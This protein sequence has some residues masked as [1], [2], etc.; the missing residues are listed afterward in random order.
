[1]PNIKC[2]KLT[3][4]DEIIADIKSDET[5][6][7]LQNPLMIMLIPANG[8]QFSVGMAPYCPYAK[9]SIVPINK[10]AVIA[11][12]EPETGMYNEYNSKY[13]SGIVVPETGF[14]L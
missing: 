9:D 4:G 7:Y 1:M 3:C 10:S 14:K 2:V 13:G 12:F 11:E 6:Y 8:N 5:H